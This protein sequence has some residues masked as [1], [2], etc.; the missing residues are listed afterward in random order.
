MRHCLKLLVFLKRCLYKNGITMFHWCF[1]FKVLFYM[2]RCMLVYPHVP[3]TQLNSFIFLSIHFIIRGLLVSF[4]TLWKK[5]TL[6]SRYLATFA[7][8]YTSGLARRQ[9]IRYTCIFLNKANV[10]IST[11]VLDP[12]F[13]NLWFL[14]F[15]SL[16]LF[17]SV[18]YIPSN[19]KNPFFN[20]DL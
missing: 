16:S 2:N 5:K 19:E 9:L 12:L 13:W 8:L 6:I 4:S 1:K 11:L 10:S 14:I 7:K 3:R 15:T 18:T 17:I 20:I